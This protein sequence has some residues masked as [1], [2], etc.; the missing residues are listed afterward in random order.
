MAL[1]ELERSGLGRCLEENG[2][3]R[4]TLTVEAIWAENPLCGKRQIVLQE[5]ATVRVAEL[6]ITHAQILAESHRL[7][8]SKAWRFTF[9]TPT[10]LTHRG[11]LVKPG[12]ITLPILLGRVFDRLESL[13]HHFCQ[14]PLTLDFAALVRRAAAARVVA[15]E[16]RWVEL[17]SY[18][19]RQKRATPIGGLVGSVLLT[20]EDWSPFAPWLVWGQFTHVGKDA[21]KGNG[22]Y[23]IVPEP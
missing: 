5:D 8:Q 12:Q 23:R 10:R 6:S 19:T 3:R 1:K 17:E 13:A 4:G 7:A 9:L 11:R 14:A 2:W 15:D 16:T 21:V 20:C 22:W 18:S